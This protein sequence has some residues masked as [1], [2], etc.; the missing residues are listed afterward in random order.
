MRLSII[1]PTLNP[2]PELARTI[3]SILDQDFG[4]LEHLIVEGGS[5]DGTLELIRKY[6]HLSLLSDG[7]EGIF[8]AMNMGIAA[9]KG[10]WV[11]FLGADDTFADD[12]VLRDLAPFLASDYD[13]VYGDVQS[14]RFN[15]RYDG[16]F[17][18]TKIRKRNI[19]HQAIFFRRT[20]FDLVGL[21]DQT[22]RS[23]ADW[24]HNMRWVLNRNIRRK[25]VDR[26]IADY[27]DHG[28]SSVN[29]DPRFRRDL[30][31]RYLTYAR[32]ELPTWKY[33]A[34]CGREL[35]SGIRQLDWPRIR[36]VLELA[37]KS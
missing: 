31:Y 25:Y 33:F 6:P 9:A 14:T 26:V 37:L 12:M 16:P 17:D 24:D 36:R 29:P 34:L 30:R 3:Q 5:T 1:T 2:G 35:G 19:C 4:D 27:A 18:A 22:Y 20:V 11:Y 23:H 13:V 21:F 15:G 8:D 10:E 32:G 28:F 7:D